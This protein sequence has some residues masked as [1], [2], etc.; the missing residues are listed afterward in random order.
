MNTIT[1]PDLSLI[2]LIGV[3]GSGKSTFAQTLQTH[4]ENLRFLKT[5]PE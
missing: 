4:R 2:V 3:S 5:T 1:I